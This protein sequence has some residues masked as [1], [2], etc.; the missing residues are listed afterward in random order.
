MV[1]YHFTSIPDALAHFSVKDVWHLG[2][3][4]STYSKGVLGGNLGLDCNAQDWHIK[5]DKSSVLCDEG[6]YCTF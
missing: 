3:S 1:S 5:D 4:P 2:Q 6:D